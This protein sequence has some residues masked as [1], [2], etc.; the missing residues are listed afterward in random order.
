MEEII[1]RIEG[2]RAQHQGQLEELRAGQAQFERLL[3]QIDELKEQREES[4][5]LASDEQLREA[6]RNGREVARQLQQENEALRQLADRIAQAEQELLSA[7]DNRILEVEQQLRQVEPERRSQLLSD[8]IILSQLRESYDRPLPEVWTVNLEEILIGV[9]EET[10]PDE[11]IA[12]VEELD[13]NERMLL[14][15]LAELDEHIR[16]LERQAALQQTT[17]GFQLESSLFEEQVSSGRRVE[18][19][20]SGSDATAATGGEG[21][22]AQDEGH[23]DNPAAPQTATGGE[24]RESGG[25]NTEPASGLCSDSSCA[26]EGYSD[27]VGGEDGVPMPGEDDSDTI[28]GDPSSTNNDQDWNDGLTPEQNVPSSPTLTGVGATDR[29]P[30]LFWL[31]EVD[32]DGDSG[33]GLQGRLGQL[34]RQRQESQ[35]T[36]IELRERREQ[37]MERALQLE[38]EEGM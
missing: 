14:A 12:T 22:S 11:I 33:V 32:V 4:S 27:G 29:D 5:A 8:L 18:R 13:D 38:Q 16:T 19:T 35:Q 24:D 34:R 37:L 10:S 3:A 2:A 25:T 6:L 20:P 1:A 17:R 7:I 31:G 28:G 30:V 15:H 9:E 21:S 36:L 26:T 23:D